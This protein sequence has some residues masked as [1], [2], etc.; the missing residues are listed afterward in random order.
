MNS[1]AIFALLTDQP[2]LL[3][4]AEI[5]NLTDWQIWRIY[6]KDR[7]ERGIPIAIPTTQAQSNREQEAVDAKVQFLN[8]GL[9]LGIKLDELESSWRRKHGGGN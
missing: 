3:R 5:A 6:G 8:M 2:Y 1:L 7:D 9:A 4:I